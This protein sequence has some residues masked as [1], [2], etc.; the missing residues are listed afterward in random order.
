MEEKMMLVGLYKDLAELFVTEVE[1]NDWRARGRLCENIKTEFRLR[2]EH[3]R[4][5]HFSWFLRNE[6]VL[7]E[8]DKEKQAGDFEV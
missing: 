3:L 1:I 8:I 5:E 6:D 2:P 7:A 4:G